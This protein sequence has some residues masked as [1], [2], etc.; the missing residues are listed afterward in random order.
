MTVSESPHVLRDYA[1]LADGHRGALVGPRGDVSWMCAP[2]WHDDAVFSA[3][4]GGAGSFVIRPLSR[5]VW[6]GHYERGGLIWRSRWVTDDGITECREAL[7]YP[8]DPHRL[9]LLRRVLAVRGPTRVGIEVQPV[10]HFGRDRMRRLQQDD[11]GS[12]RAEIDT[13]RMRVSGLPAARPDYTAAAPALTAELTLAEGDRHDI[14]LEMSDQALPER[15]P[16]A[17]LSWR[18]TEMSWGRAVPRLDASV[19]VDDA[20]QSYAVLRGLTSPGGGMVAAATLG[21]PERAKAGRNYDYR[22]VWIRDQCYAGLS[23]AVEEPLPLLDDAVA[24]V[25]ERLLAD[26]ADLRPA[27]TVDGDAVPAERSLDLPGYPGG[28]DVV[29]NQAGTQFQLDAFGEA[30]QLFAA[31]A[32][33]DHLDSTGY[34]A[35]QTAA[36]AI[37][38][39]WHRPDAGIWELDPRRWAQSRLA[40]VGGLRAAAAQAS[41]SDAAQWSSLADAII[42]DTADCSHPDGRWQRA[43]GDQRVDAALLLAALRG[44]VPADDPRSRS[45]VAAVADELSRDFYVYRFRHDGRPLHEAEGAFALCGFLMALATHQQGDPVSA[46]RYFERNRTACGPPGLLSEEYDVV[47]RQMRGNLPQA[48][49]HA[50]LIESSL[51]LAR[52]PEVFDRLRTRVVD[53]KV[54]R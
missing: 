9:V 35:M 22:Y 40:C 12:W 49:V 5:F 29:G 1:L 24:F 50:L 43:P 39:Q 52:P 17:E 36:G 31:A 14:I 3:L 2:R 8:G 23:V 6:G 16:E 37:A 7:A 19:A 41:R 21:L 27:Y 20:R 54:T 53:E 30:L 32:R 48:F 4:I 44:A 42:A 13:L 47:Q 10:A 46:F 15:P 26:G 51:V 45:T 33:L 28:N 11:D 34:R 25:G 38:D 18:S